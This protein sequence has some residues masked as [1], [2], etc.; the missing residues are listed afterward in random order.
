MSKRTVKD[1]NI[2][3]SERMIEMEMIEID[4]RQYESMAHE[5][6]VLRARYNAL[7]KVYDKLAVLIDIAKTVVGEGQKL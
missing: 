2:I 5:I 7:K 1:V 3:K 6:E 4:R